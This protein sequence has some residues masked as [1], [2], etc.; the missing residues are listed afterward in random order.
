MKRIGVHLTKL[1]S[2]FIVGCLALIIAAPVAAQDHSQHSGKA[3][4]AGKVKP[5]ASQPKEPVVESDQDVPQVEISSDQQ[6]LI[7]VKTVK[8]AFMP[9][10]KVIRTVGR[11]EVDESRQ[12]TVNAKVEGWIEKLYVDTTGSYVTKG[13]KLAEIYSP[14]LVATQQEFLTALKWSRDAAAND[15]GADKTTAS[16]LNKMLAQD[17]AATL[18]AARQRLRWWDVSEV[19]IKQIEETGKPI[20]T[21][22]LY[23][24]V[25]GYVMQKMVV[26]GMKVMP[27]EKM[28]DIADLSGL[29]VIADIYEYELPLIKVGNQAAITL[30]YLPGVE[31]MSQIDYI[32]PDINAQTRTAKVRLKLA[33]SHRQ[34]KP[35][36]FTNV[37][38][39]INL[40]R[41]LVI[42]ESAMIDT[43][44]AMVV[45]V[46]LGN[47]AFEPREIKTGIRTEGYVEVLRGLKSGEKVVAAANFLVDS[48]AQLKGIKPLP[49][50]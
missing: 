40:G 26:A 2:L 17:A 30:A 28:F 36:M 32:Y 9:M 29:W 41:K 23:A 6:K 7:G 15:T 22:T 19:Q 12:A 37:E 31:L 21:L 46:D 4:A 49:S 10:K 11:I 20:R 42:P 13:A 25:S 44:K 39:K 48:E 38:I 34:L 24:P 14:E 18:D 1:P 27:G 45:Y 35:Q 3:G 47:D 8:A 16:E 50:K 33:N 43:G 5:S